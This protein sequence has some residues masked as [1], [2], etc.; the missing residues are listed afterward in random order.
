MA[1]FLLLSSKIEEKLIL[2][3]EGEIPTSA[4]QLD[5]LE[6]QLIAKD[7]V[8]REIFGDIQ[9]DKAS[10]EG[11]GALYGSVFH[12]ILEQFTKLLSRKKNIEIDSLLSQINKEFRP[13]IEEK[14]LILLEDEYFQVL[15]QNYELRPV[16]PR[17][18]KG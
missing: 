5:K 1:P 8:R 12:T 16:L 13:K 10:Q 11:N 3:N 7:Y 2:T 4:N 14:I 9:E 6:F 15:I 18:P 17:D